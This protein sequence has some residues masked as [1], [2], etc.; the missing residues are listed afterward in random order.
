VFAASG[1]TD[2][3]SGDIQQESF[4]IKKNMLAFLQT[5]WRNENQLL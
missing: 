1:T 2:G 5:G 4:Q 3:R